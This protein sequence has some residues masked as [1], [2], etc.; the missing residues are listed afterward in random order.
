[1]RGVSSPQPRPIINSPPVSHQQERREKSHAYY[2]SEAQVARRERIKE[3]RRS[4]RANARAHAPDQTCLLDNEQ[5]EGDEEGGEEGDDEGAGERAVEQQPQ[6]VA[7]NL[8]AI[9]DDMEEVE[10]WMD[11][12]AM[13]AMTGYVQD[14]TRWTGQWG[15]KETWRDRFW[16]A[17]EM[18]DG[19]EK[20]DALAELDEHVTAGAMLFGKVDGVLEALE[21][22]TDPREARCLFRLAVRAT[23]SIMDGIGRLTF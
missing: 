18:D 8:T 1:M 9:L 17:G 12:E 13:T 2:H 6:V 20:D 19:E 10:A 16:D 23:M 11:S 21:L 3:L 5:E 22:P 14:M 4:W 7:L 15:G